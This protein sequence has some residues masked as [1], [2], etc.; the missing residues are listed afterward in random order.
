VLALATATRIVAVTIVGISSNAAIPRARAVERT[1]TNMVAGVCRCDSKL[2]SRWGTTGAWIYPV[3]DPLD[4]SAAGPEGR[5]GYR[6]NRGLERR[7]DGTLVHQGVDLDNRRAGGL[8]RAAANGLVVVADT[9]WGKG[10]G[11]R[12]V[13]AHR[14]ADGRVVF[15]VYAHLAPHSIAVGRRELVSAGVVLGRVGRS[16][17]ASTDHL[18]FE[19]RDAR[20]AEERW[21]KCATLDPLAFVAERRLEAHP[22]GWSKPYLDWAACSALIDGDVRAD[23]PLARARWWRMMARAAL[24]SDDGARDPDSLGSRLAA[25]GLIAKRKPRDAPSTIGWRELAHDVAR[26]DRVALRIPR[27]PVRASE[28]RA[29]CRNRL[30]VVAPTLRTDRLAR[31]A[32]HAPTLADACLLLADLEIPRVAKS[33]I[34]RRS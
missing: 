14:L 31:I 20:G 18:H 26:L 21:E 11:A 6:V 2:L 13:L 12:V 4:Y 16:G 32:G 8:V 3:G 23:E 22:D 7:A 17:N 28:H 27:C 1:T 10:Y 30:R 29:A 9:S 33:G 19:V 34:R 5:P 24:E 15:S 25:A